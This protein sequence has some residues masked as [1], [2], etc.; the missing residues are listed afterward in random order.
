MSGRDFTLG[1]LCI[2]GMVLSEV[3]AAGDIFMVAENLERIRDAS[4]TLRMRTVLMGARGQ[5][6]VVTATGMTLKLPG[7]ADTTPDAWLVPGFMHCSGLEL[8]DRLAGLDEEI[9]LLAAQHAGGL[10]LISACCGGFLLA[11][12]G[13][14]D[15]RR[16]TTSW[17][18]DATFRSRY[19]QVRLDVEAMVVEDGPLTTAGATTAVL[20]HLLELVARVGSPELAQLTARIMLVDPDRQSQAPYIS[21]ALTERPR[22][23]LTEKAER[24]LQRELHRELSVAELAGECGTSE[25][26]L[27][28]HFKGHFGVSP[29]RHLQ[30]LR[31]ER[32]KAL[33]ETTRLSIDEVVERC[34]YRDVSSFRKLFKRATRMTP[35]DYRE[36]F[37]LRAH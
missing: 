29:L 14:L 11:E 9:A 17:W 34:G 4:S 8:V 25:R 18:L 31:V 5:A 28:R 19:P 32:A 20:G 3:A 10:P 1:V 23:S 16:A 22:H 33:L 36:R 27:L 24:F 26:S 35:A 21:R 2:D 6:E 13:L 7:P 37:R 12:A 30:G 15:G